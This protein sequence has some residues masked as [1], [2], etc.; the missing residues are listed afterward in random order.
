MKAPE[1]NIG[2][3]RRTIPITEFERNLR[4]ND[5]ED[6]NICLDNDHF[7]II[8]DVGLYVRNG[9][10]NDILCPMT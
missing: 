9:N 4:G 3:I 2:E 1:E 10:K 8:A 7:C 6:K 5:E